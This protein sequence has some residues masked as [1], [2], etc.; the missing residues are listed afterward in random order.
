MASKKNQK[1]ISLREQK[2]WSKSEL[3]RQAGV[4]W[5]TADKAESGESISRQSELRIAKALGIPAESVF[6]SR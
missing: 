6:G 2:L 1:L 4:S 5:K 3:A